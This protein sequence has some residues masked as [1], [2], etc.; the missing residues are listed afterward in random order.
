MDIDR[1]VQSIEWQV[2]E[3]IRTTPP[4]EMDAINADFMANYGHYEQ[5]AHNY[6]AINR[7]L[8]ALEQEG[9]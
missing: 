6:G 5:P 2:D 9:V 1:F 3:W 8:T 4:D 7:V